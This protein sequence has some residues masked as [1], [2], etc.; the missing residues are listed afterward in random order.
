MTSDTPNAPIRVA[1]HGAAGRVGSEALRAVAAAP[2]MALVA[3]IDRVPPDEFALLSVPVPYYNDV[4]DALETNPA[5]VIVDFSVAAAT[6]TMAPQALALG[7]HPVIGSTGFTE[8]QIDYL[9]RL[10]EERACAAFLAPNFTIGAVLLAKLAALA[11][12]WFDYADILEE[13]HEMKIDSPS[14]TALGIA[15]AIREARPAPFERNSP[16][17]EPLPGARGADYHGV[18]IHAARMP[19]RMARHQVTFG[20]PGQTLSL[21]HDAIDRACYMPGVL[22]AIRKVGHLSGLTIGLDKLLDLS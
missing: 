20:G 7:V 4:R 21:S 15:K 22:L 3:A 18:S 9:R 19:G 2:D 8:E 6:L 5:D 16:E 11:A 12:P 1:V 14:G 17:R 13:H 10:C